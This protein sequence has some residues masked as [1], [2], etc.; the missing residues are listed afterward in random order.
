MP[1][2]VS[3]WPTPGNSAVPAS[4]AATWADMACRLVPGMPVSDTSST[5]GSSVGKRLVGTACS[6]NMLA[7]S[8]ATAPTTVMA[9]CRSAQ[10]S[11]RR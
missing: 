5:V 1:I 3:T 6:E 9:R 4:T 8:R 10:A 7:A 11:G 2:T